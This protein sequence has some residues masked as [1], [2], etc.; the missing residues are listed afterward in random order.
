[1]GKMG[2]GKWEC[3]KWECGEW[4]VANVANGAI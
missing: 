2:C 4:G 1:M 3:G